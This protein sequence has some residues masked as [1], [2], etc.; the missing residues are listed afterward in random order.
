MD[1]SAARIK[2]NRGIEILV[3]GIFI[4]LTILLFFFHELW[5]DEIQAYMLAKDAPF[6]ELIFVATH[7]EGH[8]PLFSLL[9]AIFAKTNVPV[10]IGL[11]IVSF[12][13]SMVGA[14]LVIFKAPFKKWVRC[15]IPF[16]FFIFYQ[17]T[18][19]CR[20]Y[21]MM[22]AAFMLA[23]C[24]YKTRN[25][26]PIRYILALY[27]L[28]WC[29]SY[30]LLFSGCFCVVWTVEIFKSHWG[31]D[32]GKNIAKD[33][34]FW[35]LWGILIGAL[36]ILYLIYPKPDAF[37]TNFY[38]KEHP[39]RAMIYTLFMMPADAMVTDVGFFGSLQNNSYQFVNW[40]ALSIGAYFIS[41]VVLMVVYFVSYVHRKRR[42]FLLPYIAFATFAAVGYM[43][44]HHIG[45]TVLYFVFLMWVCFDEADEERKQHRSLPIFFEKINTQYNNLIM[46]LAWFVLFLCLGMS[47]FWTG[48]S[49]FNDITHEVWYA[50]TLNGVFEKYN[51]TDYRIVADWSYLPIVDGKIVYAYG[52]TADL[53]EVQEELNEKENN[54]ETVEEE[55][56]EYFYDINIMHPEDYYQFPTLTNFADIVAYNSEGKN[57]LSN[58][59]DGDDHKRYIE[60]H[61]PSR[62]EAT[63]YCVG[64]GELGYPDIIIGDPNIVGLMGL[65]ILETEYFP[66]YEIR[67]FRPYKYHLN[68]QRSYVYLR[69][70]LVDSRD[71]WPIYDQYRSQNIY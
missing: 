27:L 46:K 40:S 62:D 4:A 24:F 63:A 36:L 31:K 20:P 35:C 23:A 51:L 58:F 32:F 30:G 49:C 37:A 47:L 65:D 21:A 11:R 45:I 25:E 42:M 16:T 10:D 14:Y 19:I 67:I 59:N 38:N 18:V 64:L 7:Y 17:Y 68:Y 6:H 53:L 43:C 61:C 56:S 50:K 52:D 39:L 5:Y 8:P 55:V 48:M 71:N 57:Y 13:F 41:I 70:D 60:H 9:L 12:A 15:L 1:N 34:R 44:N 22:F 26:K 28:C 66:I 29:S 33:K 54:S 69:S 2:E 3:L